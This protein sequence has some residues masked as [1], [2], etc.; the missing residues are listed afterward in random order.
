[1]DSLEFKIPID[2]IL[3]QNTYL[4][5][6]SH[7]VTVNGK[8]VLQHY[9]YKDPSVVKYQNYIIDYVKS[10]YSDYL[11]S[12]SEFFKNNKYS[13]EI[14]YRFKANI[15]RRDLTNPTKLVEDA[16]VRAI[17]GVFENS[18]GIKFDDSQVYMFNSYKYE[19]SN[20]SEEIVWKISHC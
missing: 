19:S 12:N 5:P 10:N 11:L 13:E 14:T 15:N 6:K 9:L 16:M 3:S 20:D 8:K 4:Q 18:E 7:Y 17:N 1:M 2:Y